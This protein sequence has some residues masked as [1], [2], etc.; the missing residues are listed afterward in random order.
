MWRKKQKHTTGRAKASCVVTFD[1][2]KSGGGRGNSYFHTKATHTA[3][4]LNNGDST[5]A[6]LQSKHSLRCGH[7]MV[8]GAFVN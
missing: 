6:L 5:M 8:R 4:Q 3:M 7:S 1:L 2:T